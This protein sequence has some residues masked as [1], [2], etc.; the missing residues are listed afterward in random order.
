MGNFNGPEH[1]PD[2]KA[3]YPVGFLS[4]NKTLLARLKSEDS[5]TGESFVVLIM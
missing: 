1:E 3:G 2:I 4:R 5:N